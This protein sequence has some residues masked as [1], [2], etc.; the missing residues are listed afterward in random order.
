MLYFLRSFPHSPGVRRPSIMGASYHSICCLHLSPLVCST[1]RT[2][3]GAGPASVYLSRDEYC[4]LYIHIYR[5]CTR[6]ATVIATGGSPPPPLLHLPN[7]PPPPESPRSSV[8]TPLP[9]SPLTPPP[10]HWTP[11]PQLLAT[12]H[13]DTS[14]RRKRTC[15]H[16]TM[17]YAC[18]FVLP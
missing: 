6:S 13:L 8:G 16:P 2:G 7:A 9:P 11:P 12:P 1:G 5:L 10:P 18:I 17:V 14:M 4:V 3:R 15:Y